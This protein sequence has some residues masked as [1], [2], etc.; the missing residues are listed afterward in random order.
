MKFRASRDELSRAIGIAQRA[1]PSKSTISILYTILIDTTDGN[2]AMTG[3]NIELGIKTS[4]VGFIEEP[5]RVCLDARMF[6]E[7]IRKFPNDDITVETDADNKA[8]IKCRKSVFHIAGKS[9]D[10]FTQLPTVKSGNEIVIGQSQLKRIIQQTI[11]SLSVN[12]SNRMMTGAYLTVTD[13]R[14]RIIALDGHRIAIRQIELETPHDNCEAIIPG[15][16][17]TEISRILSDDP[18]SKVSISIT[19]NH[20][21]FE[22]GGTTAVSSLISGNYFAVDKML[23]D[24]FRTVVRADKAHLIGSADRSM[25]FT[26]ESDKRPVVL[27]ITD[28]NMNMKIQSAIGSMSDDIPIEHDGED[29]R[30]G[31]NPKF[32][33]D[34]LKVIDEDEVSLYFVSQS[35]P[36]FIRDTDKSF[37]Y[38]ILPV[39]L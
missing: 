16:T 9:A 12:D 22:F 19:N 25:L 31:V 17:L 39:S 4:A 29:L 1:V 7:I 11:F 15:K 5:G 32:L 14:L 26:S 23:T 35:T 27:D 2:I 6:S 21:L 37:I 34:V 28:D 24:D 10:D 8:T 36:L 38:M 13:N 18:E 3:N 30:I 20:A 33:L